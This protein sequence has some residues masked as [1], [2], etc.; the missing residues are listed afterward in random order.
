MAMSLRDF[1]RGDSGLNNLPDA[2]DDNLNRGVEGN[3]P[4]IG[5]DAFEPSWTL[6]DLP[7][8]MTRKQLEELQRQIRE[9]EDEN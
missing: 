6:R 3:R 5:P 9:D 1:R 8:G 4:G 2:G 7:E